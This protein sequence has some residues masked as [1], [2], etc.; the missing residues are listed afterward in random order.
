MYMFLATFLWW[1]FFSAYTYSFD[2]DS[3]IN[4][5]PYG[6]F[7]WSDAQATDENTDLGSALWD[8]INSDEGI[9]KK[10]LEAFGFDTTAED[11]WAFSYIRNLINYALVVIWLVAMAVF[12]F[13]FYKIFVSDGEEWV[14]DAK[15]IV[16]GAAIALA[17]IG[18][19]RFITR[20]AFSIFETST[21][22]I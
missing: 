10:L 22:G 6:D 20:F 13:W 7:M 16:I 15:K 1:L 12:I 8:E 18:L 3:Y 2:F 14:A 17:V 5:E 9:L 19:A 21:D 11:L 4:A